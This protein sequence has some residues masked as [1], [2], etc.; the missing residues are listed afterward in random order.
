[1]HWT[2]WLFGVFFISSIVMLNFVKQFALYIRI[3]LL[4]NATLGLCFTWGFAKYK[5]L[6]ALSDR[7][8]KIAEENHYEVASYSKLNDEW[9]ASLKRGQQL[10]NEFAASVGL[11]QEDAEEIEKFQEALRSLINQKKK[12]QAE[13]KAMLLVSTRHQHVTRKNITEKKRK[14]IKKRALRAYDK[15]TRRGSLVNS[16]DTS[17]NDPTEIADFKI[18]LSQKFESESSNFPVEWSA[19]MMTAYDALAAD[20]RISKYALLDELDKATESY[21]REIRLARETTDSLNTE[22]VL[23]KRKELL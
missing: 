19:N 5:S 14:L 2:E 16:S 10:L 6:A 13:E 12:V 15:I 7:L 1:M 4:A 8:E 23:V 3:L 21:F 20:G 22:L 17:L 9:D 18:E 11:V